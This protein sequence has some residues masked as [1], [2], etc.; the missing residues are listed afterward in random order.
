MSLFYLSLYTYTL[1]ALNHNNCSF[2]YLFYSGYSQFC[3]FSFLSLW[4]HLWIIRATSI[5]NFC[6]CHLPLNVRD[7]SLID[8]CHWLLSRSIFYNYFIGYVIWLSLILSLVSLHFAPVI[9][10]SSI[11]IFD[12]FF[13]I[14]LHLFILHTNVTIFYYP[15]HFLFLYFWPLRLYIYLT[16]IVPSTFSN[17]FYPNL[18]YTS[19]VITFLIGNKWYIDIFFE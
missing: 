17:G 13:C 18:Y 9:Q 3:L 14:C 5:N 19:I 1:F 8:H 7:K 11:N 12:L 15:S 2:L 4:I 6:T 16:V 10:L